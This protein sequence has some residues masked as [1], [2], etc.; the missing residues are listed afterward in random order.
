MNLSGISIP[1]AKLD[2]MLADSADFSHANLTGVS[3]RQAWL[4]GS[5][6]REAVMTSVQF[7]EYP[8]INFCRKVPSFQE[9][10]LAEK[11]GMVVAIGGDS[12]STFNSLTGEV[13]RSWKVNF[14][15]VTVPGWGDKTGTLLTR[16][17]L[18]GNTILTKGGVQVDG[19]DLA[20]GEH[21]A[22]WFAWKAE[23][24]GY[25]T[26]LYSPSHIAI[27]K[28]T[29]LISTMNKEVRI[30]AQVDNL[31]HKMMSTPTEI[32][33][34]IVSKGSIIIIGTKDGTVWMWDITTCQQIGEPMA[35]GSKVI[36]MTTFEGKIVAGSED[37]IVRMW[38]MMTG[39]QVGAIVGGHG[40]VVVSMA[41]FEGKLICGGEDNM[42]WVW[43]IVTCKQLGEAMKGHVSIVTTVRVHGGRV[44]SGDG[45]G[46]VRMWD[47]PTPAVGVI[48]AG[49][50]REV[51][52][53][54]IT[55]N[56]KIISG[57]WD[58]TI[59]T[60]DLMTGVQQACQR[61]KMQC[62]YQIAEE[63]GRIM[64]AD[65]H[66]EVWDLA[67]GQQVVKSQGAENASTTF[68]VVGGKV[69]YAS[70]ELMVW[71]IVT[72][73]HVDDF[74]TGRDSPV[75]S[76][77]LKIVFYSDCDSFVWW[78][79][80][81][82][83]KLGD[84]KYKSDTIVAVTFNG[85]IF[86]GLGNTVKIID[87]STMSPTNLN[88]HTGRVTHVA[89]FKGDQEKLISGSEDKT[90]RVWD[91]ASGQCECVVR[92]DFALSSIAC[93]PPWVVIGSANRVQR[94]K[95]DETKKKMTLIGMCPDRWGLHLGDCLV[96]AVSGL[97]AE[98]MRLLRQHHARRSSV[99]EES[100][101]ESE[102]NW[103]EIGWS[104]ISRREQSWMEAK[105]LEESDKESRE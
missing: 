38:D 102:I 79:T 92:L 78:D 36:R 84:E 49:H 76:K 33:S 75:P 69:F 19:W 3:L 64:Y 27:G 56:G 54:I 50:A 57:S 60:W 88:G 15:P 7:G 80:S 26:S 1:N 104:D 98:Q 37:G 24:D 65:N 42:V 14:K 48:N 93:H 51:T 16:L 94:W 77:D 99:E 11:E 66:A 46:V 47:M 31:Q 70:D 55:T 62:I 28:E 61:T 45:E 67:S 97:S 2:N 44:I 52:C 95:Y 6:L 43:D 58:G 103:S 10:K 13:V 35:C 63:E 101:E 39:Q 22:T 100:Y 73:Q 17:E 8:H 23:E 40:G 90:V 12:V 34:L 30:Y 21:L 105:R 89:V 25:C 96:D 86:I 29:L 20:T 32:T 59:R 81:T 74:F 85:K 82:G 53:I 83:K 4:R 68:A 9:L 72:G 18:S 87:I 41:T 91:L 5:D 71:D